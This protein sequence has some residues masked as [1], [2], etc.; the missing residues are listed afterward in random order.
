MPD[1]DACGQICPSCCQLRHAAAP[2]TG[3]L[4]A[5]RQQARRK[6]EPWPSQ[7]A[8][9]ISVLALAG[10]AGSVQAF[11]SVLRRAEDWWLRLHVVGFREVDNA[12]PRLGWA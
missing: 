10:E 2:A 11:G 6:T 7:Q 9:I 5:I 3:Q 4:P 1:D 8:Q 12:G